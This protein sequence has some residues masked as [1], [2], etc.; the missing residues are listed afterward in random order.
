[1]TEQITPAEVDAMR[2]E[3]PGVAVRN[4]LNNAG[5]AL[6]PE[7]V[8]ETVSSHLRLEAEIGGY[9]AAAQ[10]KPKLDR[11]YDD[12]AE[13]IG[14]EADEIA[15]MQN[16][17]AAWLAA[18]HALQFEPGDEILTAEAEYAANYV[19][20]LQRAKRD[21]VVVRTVPSDATGGLDL[22]ALQAMIGP[23]TKLIA[24]TW[25]PTNGGLV[26]PAAEVGAIARA[27][28]VPYLLD[29]CQAVGQLPVDVAALGCD[30]LAATGRKWLRGPRGTG[31]LYVARRWL[32]EG[33]EPAILDHAGGPWVA[34]DR[35]ELLDSAR[36]FE[37]WETPIALYLGLGE[38]VRQ[39]QATGIERISARIAAL[40]E[41]AREGLATIPGVTVR[42]LGGV[43]SGLVTFDHAT[44][45]A[46][47]IKAELTARAINVTVSWPSS[48]RLDS[49]RRGLGP[50]VRMSPHAYNTE[51][52]VERAVMA[53]AEIVRAS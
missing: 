13:L 37:L 38:A 1:M 17:T 41:V 45:P 5:A 33:I 19:S 18:F 2:A 24:I 14:A 26:N 43:K 48:T 30:F 23:K 20:F 21:G 11:V 32:V 44:V 9:E 28:G 31:F 15:L 39:A 47:Q 10:E 8:L 22:D 7:P 46:E 12:V 16:A 50:M 36:R 49:E 3:T 6:S 40:S 52:E 25:V 29:A 51:S 27:S 35:Y 34:A 4:H 53:V 42:D